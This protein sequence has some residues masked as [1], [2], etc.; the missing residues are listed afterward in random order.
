[1][2]GGA[3]LLVRGLEVGSS[4]QQKPHQFGIGAHVERR[5]TFWEP[6][7][8]VCAGVQQS[9]DCVLIAVVSG[10][11]EVCPSIPVLAI[12][13]GPL[14]KQDSSHLC[15]IA[16]HRQA[17]RSRAI[18]VRPV[19]L[20]ALS[21][22]TLYLSLVTVCARLM[23]WWQRRI[24]GRVVRQGPVVGARVLGRDSQAAEDALV[25]LHGGVSAKRQVDRV[26]GS[27][28]HVLGGLAARQIEFGK[29]SGAVHAGDPHAGEPNAEC[30]PRAE[31]Q[32]V[33]HRP[34]RARPGEGN[35]DGMSFE[36][37][38]L[39][40][41]GHLFPLQ[42]EVGGRASVFAVYALLHVDLL[43]AHHD[44]LAE[45]VCGP[46][47]LQ[48]FS[49]HV[50]EL[51][52]QPL[53]GGVEPGLDRGLRDGEEGAD[54]SIAVAIDVKERDSQALGLR[55]G[56]KGALDGNAECSDLIH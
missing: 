31:H 46:L 25:H 28:V 33:R 50:R 40:G 26:G 13:V 52:A 55:K 17:Q 14:R 15:M 45:V 32:V 24:P 16:Y 22:Q 8:D 27:A 23:E 21:E 44:L 43:Y 48:A 54:L 42:D 53:T 38:D 11:V 34:R 36:Q 12:R 10:E 47:G 1:M 9:A 6:D 30:R 5:P 2:E 51:P 35:T 20:F 49:D 29:D 18:P 3:A 37:P 7:V 4:R 41:N 56:G 39:D 19:G